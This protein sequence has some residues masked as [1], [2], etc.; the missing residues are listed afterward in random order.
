MISNLEGKLGSSAYESLVNL[1]NSQ[2]PVG[3]IIGQPS[4]VIAQAMK[5]SGLDEEEVHDEDMDDEEVLH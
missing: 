3:D 1:V 5:Q 4:S 2:P